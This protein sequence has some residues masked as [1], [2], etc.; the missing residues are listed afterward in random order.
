MLACLL[1]SLMPRQ[2]PKPSP[3]T[4]DPVCF[5]PLEEFCARDKCL[6]YAAQVQ[7]LKA[8]GFETELDIMKAG[9]RGGD[10]TTAGTVG[11]CGAFRITHR[12]DG[13]TGETRYFNKAGK[14]VAV[15]AFFDVVGGEACPG[16]RHYGASTTCQVTNVKLLCKPEAG[17]SKKE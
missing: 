5:R 12:S 8:G 15:R 13:F 9:G 2:T 6:A 17:R 14:L 1:M 4:G 7:A 3:P 11:R 16:W 10:C